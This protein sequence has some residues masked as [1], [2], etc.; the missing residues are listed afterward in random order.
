MKPNFKKK[1]NSSPIIPQLD[2]PVSSKTVSSKPFWVDFDVVIDKPPKQQSA[3]QKLRT[4]CDCS[5]ANRET[6]RWTS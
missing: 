2:T 4:A 6:F 1:K 5:K 3:V